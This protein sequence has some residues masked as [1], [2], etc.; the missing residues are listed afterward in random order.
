[1]QRNTK[2]AGTH[3]QYD[4]AGRALYTLRHHIRDYA[5]KRFPFMPVTASAKHYKNPLSIS[6]KRYKNPPS[7]VSPPYEL[8]TAAAACSPA[9]PWTAR[10]VALI[11]ASAAAMAEGGAHA[12]AAAVA[13]ATA[14]S[15]ATSPPKTCLEIRSELHLKS[16]TQRMSANDYTAAAEPFL[17]VERRSNR[18]R[19]RR[20]IQ[21]SRAGARAAATEE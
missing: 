5:Q 20:R 6:T 11:P 12:P 7:T 3:T 10:D 13:M 21:K 18:R 17:I 8:T 19:K 4:A 16:T 15:L 9:I 2:V 14:S 1:M